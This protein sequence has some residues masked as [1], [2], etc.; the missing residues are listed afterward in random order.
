L[1]NSGEVAVALLDTV[2]ESLVVPGEIMTTTIRE[3]IERCSPSRYERVPTELETR[4]Q[5]IWESS[6]ACACVDNGKFIVRNVLGSFAV[7]N[8]EEGNRNG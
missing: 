5:A 8:A 2:D 1:S 6:S 3:C 4:Q 7:N